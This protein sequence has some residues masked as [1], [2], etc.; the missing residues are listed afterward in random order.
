[1]VTG[2]DVFTLCSC[3]ELALCCGRHMPGYPRIDV[4]NDYLM[5]RYDGAIVDG[6]V[7]HASICLKPCFR[8]WVHNPTFM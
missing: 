6:Q 2:P 1:M 4:G 5:A 7:A 3:S 8:F